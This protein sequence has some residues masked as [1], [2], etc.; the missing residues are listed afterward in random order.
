MH[1]GNSQASLR[2]HDQAKVASASGDSG[3]GLPS[4][5]DVLLGTWLGHKLDGKFNEE[6]FRAV[7]FVS[8]L[9]ISGL[10]LLPYSLLTGN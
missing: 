3:I 5:P 4:L 1:N 10:T 7:V 2:H 9:L 6:T 8:L